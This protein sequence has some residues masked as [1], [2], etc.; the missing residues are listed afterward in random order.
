MQ[1]MKPIT[2]QKGVC[3]FISL[4]KD[5]HNTRERISHTLETITNLTSSKVI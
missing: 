4:V 5:Y 2:N 1:N 3:K